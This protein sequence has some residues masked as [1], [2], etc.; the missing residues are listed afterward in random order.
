VDCAACHQDGCAQV[1]PYG[2]LAP[3]PT[4]KD[5]ARLRAVAL[6]ATCH[7]LEAREH[8]TLYRRD[9]GGERTCVACHMPAYCDRLTQ[10]KLLSGLHPRRTVRDHSMSPWR[11]ERLAGV[12]EIGR[13]RLAGDDV[14]ISLTNR[15]AGHRV[16][17][18]RCG[19]R[20]L[21]IRVTLLDAHGEPVGTGT[22]SFLGE[23]ED[24]L[25]PGRTRVL[26][27]AL[28]RASRGAPT[29]LRVVVDHVDGD[30]R[31]RA[32]LVDRIVALIGGR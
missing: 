19:H 23:R 32:V 5:G 8:E 6:C 30:G 26:H 9:A 28:A 7:E 1:G 4:R 21:R 22:H 29:A 16:P 10:G 15:G 31:V 17:T 13:A 25:E 3:H 27:M 24:G 2:A 11:P 12:L 18:G 20:E 14:V